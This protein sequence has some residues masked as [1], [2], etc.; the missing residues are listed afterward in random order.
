MWRYHLGSLRVRSQILR[1][2]V[3]INNLIV[4][5][6]T[7]SLRDRRLRFTLVRGLGELIALGLL[8]EVLG[9]SLSC[10]S[11]FV[12]LQRSIC[13]VIFKH[14]IPLV[15][16]GST[17]LFGCRDHGSVMLQMN[18]GR[19]FWMCRFDLSINAAWSLFTKSLLLVDCRHR[20][21]F[22]TSTNFLWWRLLHA[23]T[24]TI[25][26]IPQGVVFLLQLFFPPFD[27][28]HLL[29]ILLLSGLRRDT[30]SGT[31]DGWPRFRSGP[32]LR[33]SFI[34]IVSIPCKFFGLIDLVFHNGVGNSTGVA[35]WIILLSIEYV[36]IGNS[37]L[38]VLGE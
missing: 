8:R 21:R 1:W 28:T 6:K 5:I 13:R 3:V 38:G 9:E 35:I 22:E 26:Y 32:L 10:I 31:A 27:F 12:H 25:S 4:T 23:T 33:G 11:P 30:G 19:Y 2:S 17:V 15:L 20:A 29:L 34:L 24:R 18:F 16:L 14:H 7:L 37:I 36:H